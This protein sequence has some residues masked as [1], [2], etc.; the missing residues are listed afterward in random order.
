MKDDASENSKKGQ[1]TG[2]IQILVPKK[3]SLSHRLRTEDVFFL[4]FVKNL[5]H[6]DPNKRPTATEALKHAWF[7][8]ITY[9]D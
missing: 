2:K 8:K 1:K 7:T 4:D 9:Q 6:I 3:S 5:L